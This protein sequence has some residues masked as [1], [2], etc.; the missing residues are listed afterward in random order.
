MVSRMKVTLT[1]G[2]AAVAVVATTVVPAAAV[3]RETAAEQESF[4]LINEARSAAGVA[5]LAWADDLAEVAAAWSQTMAVEERQYHNPDYAEQICCWAMVAE[6]VGNRRGVGDYRTL[7]EAVVA[8]HEAFMDSPGHRANILRAS[9]D[10]VGVGVALTEDGRLWVTHNFRARAVVPDPVP[11]PEPVPDPA[12]TP[13]PAPAPAPTP[14]PLPGWEDDPVHYPPIEWAPELPGEEPVRVPPARRAPEPSTAT[15]TLT[16]PAPVPATA[17]VA[18]TPAASAPAAVSETSE[19]AQRPTRVTRRS[20]GWLSRHRA[21][22]SMRDQLGF[23]L[24]MAAA[25]TVPTVEL[26]EAADAD[27]WPTTRAELVRRWGE[28]VERYDGR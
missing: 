13:D 14:E 5:P 26:D 3:A 7:E 19:V 9:F 25:T 8:M 6:N 10:E 28:H 23:D 21:F 16:R 11:D 27:G 15:S 20:P 4:A 22:W 12:P 17:G 18:S 1:A 2:L 24:A